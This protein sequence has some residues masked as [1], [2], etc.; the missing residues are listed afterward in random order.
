ME[1]VWQIATLMP[2]SAAGRRTRSGSGSPG[3]AMRMARGKVCGL[4]NFSISSLTAAGVTLS[5][6]PTSG[7]SVPLEQRQGDL[8][9]DQRR[10]SIRA[11]QGQRL[12]AVSALA[13]RGVE[14][15][16][17]EQGCP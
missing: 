16:L 7:M 9:E 13:E 14:R 15:D 8:L 17:A 1:K 11:G 10:G 2:I 5:S 3:L 4:T 12:P 6:G